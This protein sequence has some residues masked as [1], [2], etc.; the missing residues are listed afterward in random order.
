VDE[1]N[2]NGA[3]FGV[4][5]GNETSLTLGGNL[6]Y[7]KMFPLGGRKLVANCGQPANI[8]ALRLEFIY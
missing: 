4:N 7:V 5:G 2:L 6:N 3:K 8:V 1:V